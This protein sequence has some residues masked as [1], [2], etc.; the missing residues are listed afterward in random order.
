MLVGVEP[1][2]SRV[3]IPQTGFG[4]GNVEAIG[5]RLYHLVVDK[6]ARVDI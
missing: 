6:A 3:T 2:Y 4:G 5:P 1:L